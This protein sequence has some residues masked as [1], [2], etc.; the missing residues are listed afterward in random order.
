[1]SDNFIDVHQ[2]QNRDQSMLEL[3]TSDNVDS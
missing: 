1:M 3:H 2:L